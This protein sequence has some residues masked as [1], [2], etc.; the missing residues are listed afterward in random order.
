MK[1]ALPPIAL[2]LSHP[3]ATFYGVGLHQDTVS[4]LFQ[5]H[6]NDQPFEIG[7]QEFLESCYK[8]GILDDAQGGT[9]YI[10]GDRTDRNARQW[11]GDWLRENAGTKDFFRVLADAIWAEFALEM[12]AILTELQR[13]TPAAISE[14]VFRNK[15]AALCDAVLALADI[16]RAANGYE[17]DVKAANEPQPPTNHAELVSGLAVDVMAAGHKNVALVLH[18]LAGSM[19]VG[20]DPA[21]AIIASDFNER[22]L[23]PYI[24]AGI[25]AKRA[26]QN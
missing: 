20:L 24:K 19:H 25:A 11:T 18:V 12:S 10:V 17:A 8:C 7:F 1:N 26:A 4:G 13:A 5:A 23:G 14:R 15:D 6:D 21:L 22:V 9:V 2:Q 3:D 16:I